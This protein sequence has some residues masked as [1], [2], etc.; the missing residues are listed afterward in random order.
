MKIKTN[1]E[2]SG[3]QFLATGAVKAEDYRRNEFNGEVKTNENGEVLYRADAVI[4][5]SGGQAVRD[6]VSI[7]VVHPVDLD[8]LAVYAPVGVME[9]NT[10]DRFKTSIVVDSLVKVSK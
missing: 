9:V 6:Q 5:L 3:V 2:L 1:A 4:V 8:A 10:Y 7:S